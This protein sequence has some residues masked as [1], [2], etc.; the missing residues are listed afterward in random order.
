MRIRQVRHVARKGSMPTYRKFRF[1]NKHRQ[2][3]LRKLSVKEKAKFTLE[4]ATKAQK[5]SRGI[6]LLF[7]KTER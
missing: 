1:E 2:N 3:P 6:A 5:G 7:L 4:Q